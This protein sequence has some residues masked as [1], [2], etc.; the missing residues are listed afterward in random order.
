MTP[1]P[2]LDDRPLSDA[3]DARVRRALDATDSTRGSA[4]DAV[5]ARIAGRSPEAL[6]DEAAASRVRT[7]A[8]AAAVL[9]FVLSMIAS[10]SGSKSKESHV[11]G[12]NVVAVVTPQ[13]SDESATKEGVFAEL[14][15][16][17]VP[18]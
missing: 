2:P 16:V 11:D 10:R 18:E 9:L 4:R 5:L 15:A 1:H 13:D 17:E 7:L 6:N 8:Q 14:F 12:S 3:L